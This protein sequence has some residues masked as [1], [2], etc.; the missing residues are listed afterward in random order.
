MRNETPEARERRLSYLIKHKI[1]KGQIKNPMGRGV[2]KN[3]WKWAAKLGT[4][5]KFVEPMRKTFGI[6]YGKLNVESAI[7]LRLVHEALQGDIRAI[8]LWMDRK[9]GKVTQPMDISTENGPLV[10]ILNAPQGGQSIHVTMAQK[11]QIK[12]IDIP[13]RPEDPR[14]QLTSPEDPTAPAPK[15]QEP[16]ENNV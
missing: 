15:T 4:P 14:P 13:P 16:E 2:G 3:I 8:E 10:A 5:N 7:V 11:D 9:Y 6:P 1:K 12:L